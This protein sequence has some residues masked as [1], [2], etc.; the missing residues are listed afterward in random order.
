MSSGPRTECKATSFSER[1]ASPAATL[2]AHWCPKSTPIHRP[3]PRTHFHGVP[4]MVRSTQGRRGSE[5]ILGKKPRPSCPAAPSPMSVGFPTPLPAPTYLPWPSRLP[6]CCRREQEGEGK[7]RGEQSRGLETKKGGGGTCHRAHTAWE[8]QDRPGHGVLPLSQPKAESQMLSQKRDQYLIGAR[9]ALCAKEVVPGITS[10][11]LPHSPEGVSPGFMYPAGK[12]VQMSR[13]K[14]RGKAGPLRQDSFTAPHTGKLT[15]PRAGFNP[16][17][18]TQSCAPEVSGSF[19]TGPESCPGIAHLSRH[20]NKPS[21]WEGN[22]P[23]SQSPER[24]LSSGFFISQA[25]QVMMPEPQKTGSLCERPSEN[26]TR[27]EVEFIRT[28]LKQLEGTRLL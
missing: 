26:H 14:G 3:R 22:M 27:E 10:P 15:W 24:E 18:E 20:Q 5:R 11:C 6:V 19:A 12:C 8:P 1:T 7:L 28:I 17:L 13:F 2:P 21:P 9:P 16:G 25:A 4:C 23:P